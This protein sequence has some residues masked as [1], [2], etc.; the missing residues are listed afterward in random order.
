M[1]LRGFQFLQRDW[2]K[3]K[4]ICELCSQHGSNK[5]LNHKSYRSLSVSR[6][7]GARPPGT[8]ETLDV[9]HIPLERTRNFSIIAHIDHGKSTL[10]DRLLEITETISPGEGNKQVLDRLQVEQERGITVKAQ[11]ASLF[12]THN[13]EEYLLNLIDTPGHVDFSYEV[14]RSLQACQGV[15]LLVDANKG[16]QAQTVANFFLAF[17]SDLAIVSVVNKIDLKNADP[18]RAIAQMQRLF[19]CDPDKVCRISAKLG[20]NVQSVLTAVIEDIPPPS[21]C[22]RDEPLRALIFDSWFDRYKGCVPLVAVVDGQLAAGDVIVSS[23]SG[24]SYEVREVGLLRPQET[25]ATQLC[26]GQVGYLHANI[27]T[28]TEAQVG[29]TL[30]LKGQSVTPLAGFRRAKPM[31]YAGVYPMDQSQVPNL[32]SAIERLTLNDSSV[33]VQV[34]SSA[35]LGQGWRLG[36]LG[37]LHMDVFTQRLQQEYDSEVVVTSPSVPYK[38]KIFGAK[39]IKKY[40]GDEI[41]INGPAQFPDVMIVSEFMEPMVMG[42]IITPDAYFGAVQAL[43]MERRGHQSEATNIDNERIMVRATMPLSE[44]VVDFYDELKSLT[45]GYASFDYEDAGYETTNLSKLVILLNGEPVEELSL[46]VHTSRARSIGRAVCAR[47]AE[48]IPRQMFSVA[49]QAAVGGKILAR[50]DVK[51]LKKDVLAK[52]Y[53]GD[54]SRKMKLLKR[55][56]EGKRRMKRIANI[57]IPRET[58]VKVLKR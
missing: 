27:R 18:D 51:A 24:Q 36:F 35:A 52:C 45:S 32:R 1:A 49:I 22:R 13:G 57:D 26:A 37:L 33:S 50:A 25:P 29:D 47:L 20:T 3:T 5:W 11:T 58:F 17:T 16:V 23:Q 38:A 41:E 7:H 19:D 46:I 14:S 15:V 44:V 9:S 56:A 10:A 43:V 4:L 31:V 48:S 28:A 30:Y 6:S 42:T 40:R 21:Q 39:N 54:I 12:Y 55:Q 2:K 8:T 34:E 53:G